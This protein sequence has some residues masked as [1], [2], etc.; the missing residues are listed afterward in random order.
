MLKKKK[1]KV[2]HDITVLYSK[3]K[4]IITFI[5][6]Y[7]PKSLKVFLK[8]LINF[9][10]KTITATSVPTKPLQR[11]EVKKMPQWVVL[12][13]SLLREKILEAKFSFY[14]KLRLV[15]V[16]Y[17]FLLEDPKAASNHFKLKLG[18]NHPVYYKLPNSISIFCYKYVRVTMYGNTPLQKLTQTAAKIRNLRPPEPYKGKGVLYFNETIRLKVGKQV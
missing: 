5:G 18:H 13:I 12:Q 7:G 1:L 17:R 8:V 4:N 14:L 9:D 16:G 6:P 15:G 2:P 3:S 10:T 11:N